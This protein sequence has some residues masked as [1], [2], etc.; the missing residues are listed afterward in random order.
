MT[1]DASI[2]RYKNKD[3]RHACNRAGDG[4]AYC[5]I[6]RAECSGRKQGMDEASCEYSQDRKNPSTGPG[7][8]VHACLL[9]ACVKATLCYFR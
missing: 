5:K 1:S 7:P 2:G 8:V 6:V 3:G 4:G 9:L